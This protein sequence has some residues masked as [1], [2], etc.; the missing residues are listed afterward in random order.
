MSR[1]L[2]LFLAVLVVSAGCE[3]TAADTARPNVLFIMSDDHTSQAPSTKCPPRVEAAELRFNDDPP[4]TAGGFWG[5]N[6]EIPPE[7]IG[8]GAALMRVSAGSGAA[9]AD[10]TPGRRSGARSGNCLSPRSYYVNE[11]RVIGCKAQ[12]RL[13]LLFANTL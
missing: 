12:A 6:G 10:R 3:T 5:R 11:I 8:F 7:A 13:V 9:D 1:T 2:S 4:A